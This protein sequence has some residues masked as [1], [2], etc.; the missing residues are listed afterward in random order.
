MLVGEIKESHGLNDK[1]GTN[2]EL[3]HKTHSLGERQGGW[4][5]AAAQRLEH[6]S[7][8]TVCGSVRESFRADVAD[9]LSEAEVRND[10]P[11]GR[12][13]GKGPIGPY[14]REDV[15]TGTGGNGR[16]LLVLGTPADCGVCGSERDFCTRSG[17]HEMGSNADTG[18][19]TTRS[20]VTRCEEVLSL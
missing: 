17:S 10:S 8:R 14:A 12:A 11:R 20:T 18:A 4:G 13:S 5:G 15:R 9:A 19:T 1:Y 6:R 16:L 7:N 3:Q 2:K